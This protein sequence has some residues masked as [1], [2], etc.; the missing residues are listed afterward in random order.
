VSV[1]KGLKVQEFNGS[2]VKDKSKV[3]NKDKN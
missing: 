3:K 1:K 2:K